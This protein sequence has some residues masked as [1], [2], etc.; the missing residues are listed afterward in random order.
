MK[1]LEF[2]KNP[3][4]AAKDV[5]VEMLQRL[6]Q[7]IESGEIAAE[8]AVVVIVEPTYCQPFGTCLTVPEALGYLEIAKKCILEGAE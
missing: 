4:R 8:A 6:V 1:L 5:V 7:Q 2:P 3:E